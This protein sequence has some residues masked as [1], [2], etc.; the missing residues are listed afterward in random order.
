VASDERQDRIMQIDD[1]PLLL[2]ARRRT[3]GARARHQDEP[4]R[5][6]PHHKTFVAVLR[7]RVA[8]LLIAGEAGDLAMSARGQSSS[9]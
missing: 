6:P 2:R 4:E 8:F 1:R 5:L 7:H 3:Y 9:G